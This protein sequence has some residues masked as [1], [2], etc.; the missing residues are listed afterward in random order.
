MF[1]V[2]RAEVRRY[3][4]PFVLHPDSIH[5]V[6]T[7]TALLLVSKGLAIASPYI[8]KL[9]VDAMAPGVA[10]FQMVAWGIFLGGAT[11]VL[12]TAAQEL[13]MVQIARLIQEGVRR[14][15]SK[16]FAHMHT[17]DLNFHKAS[18]KNTVFGINRALRSIESG[19]RFS[20]GFAAPIAFE[21]VLLCGMLQF[22]CGPLYL[23]NMLATLGLYAR[24]T[25]RSSKKRVVY[26]RDRKNTEKK[27]EFTQNESIMNYETVKVFGNEKL[28]QQKYEAILANLVKQ[29]KVVQTTLS[30]LNIGQALIFSVGLTI[31][32]LMAAHGVSTGAMT[33]GDFV[34]IQALFLQ[35]SGPL[36]NMGTFFREIDQSSVDV[37]DLF[38][39]LKQQPLVKEA[40]DAKKFEFKSG[41]I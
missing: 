21:F 10:D 8:L 16:S 1:R 30:E 4:Q 26:I 5:L 14:V 40:E 33:T 34:M 41:G 17:L 39:M 13:R 36:F 7:S 24:F 27:Q 11:R 12:G 32:L 38:H 9:V 28:E 35:L 2:S 3:I 22:Y 37:E 31:N 6:Y 23:F 20:I 15:A 19:L 18:S 29:A 25:S